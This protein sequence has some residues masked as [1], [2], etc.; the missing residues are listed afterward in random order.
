MKEAS[1]VTS[2]TVGQVIYRHKK[3]QGEPLQ[4]LTMNPIMTSVAGLLFIASGMICT[5]M[6]LDL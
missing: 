3:K 4:R 6:Y 2:K 1:G 5:V